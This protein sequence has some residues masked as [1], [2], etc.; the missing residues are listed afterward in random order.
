MLPIKPQ[1]KQPN[2]TR[3]IICREMTLHFQSFFQ[4]RIFSAIW[5]IWELFIKFDYPAGTAK[6]EVASLDFLK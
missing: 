5:A 2:L 3:I 4:T 1:E 6:P